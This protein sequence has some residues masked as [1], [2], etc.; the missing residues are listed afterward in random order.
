MF[1]KSGQVF[2]HPHETL[3]SV[4]F[5]FLKAT[6]LIFWH[7]AYNNDNTTSDN[8]MF[9]CDVIKLWKHFVPRTSIVAVESRLLF[10]QLKRENIA[11]RHGG[12]KGFKSDLF[13]L[14]IFRNLSHRSHVVP[15][16]KCCRFFKAREVLWRCKRRCF[17][18]RWTCYGP[19]YSR[20]R[21]ASYKTYKPSKIAFVWTSSSEF[22]A[23]SSC[24]DGFS[25]N[26]ARQCTRDSQWETTHILDKGTRFYKSNCIGVL[27]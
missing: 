20:S 11:S 17:R 6:K 16:R 7:Y 26:A 1:L 24:E 15:E 10:L 4:N 3:R 18:S 27:F 25:K 19:K 14:W 23:R 12:T 22:P 9:H 13:R 5:A 2:A 8:H 21:R